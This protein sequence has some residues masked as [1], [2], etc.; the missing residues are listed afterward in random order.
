[1]VERALRAV[2][3]AEV[4]EAGAE[5]AHVVDAAVLIEA[6]VLDGEHGVLH[7]LRDLGDRHEV[8]AL[9][10]EL[11]EQHAVGGEH[12][13]RQL[14]PVVGEAADLRQVRDT[15]PRAR[16]RRPARRR[17]QPAAA[18]PEQAS[19]TRSTS[20]SQRGGR[21]R[22]RARVARRRARR[23]RVRIRSRLV[24][25]VERIIETRLRRPLRRRP[26]AARKVTQSTLRTGC[27]RLT[28]SRD[29]F[30][31]EICNATRVCAAWFLL[32]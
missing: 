15:T 28:C 20:R 30:A 8:A 14:R 27:K 24:L 18:K 5:H 26:Q 1:M 21:P 25:H 19:T 2:A 4:G 9:L 17:R 12:A 16:C 29:G 13:H 11:A 7:D 23:R 6:G 10:A 22:R 3:F 32:W 31:C